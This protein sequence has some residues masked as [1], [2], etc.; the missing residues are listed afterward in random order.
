[1]A[2]ANQF[3]G[4]IALSEGRPI[5]SNLA[6]PASEVSCLAA[7]SEIPSASG[8]LLAALASL[9]RSARVGYLA[10]VAKSKLDAQYWGTTVV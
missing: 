10:F 1:M 3:D 8:K 9:S 4:S 2:Y 6:P 7:R 5:L